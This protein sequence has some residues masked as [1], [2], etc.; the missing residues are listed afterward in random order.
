MN[1]TPRS[2]PTKSGELRASTGS[3]CS[4]RSPKMVDNNKETSIPIT[5]EFQNPPIQAATFIRI[6]GYLTVV[7]YLLT[8]FVCKKTRKLSSPLYVSFMSFHTR[9]S[10]LYLVILDL[11][12][13]C[14]A[15]TGT[16]KKLR[17][18]VPYFIK[19][20]SL[21]VPKYERTIMYFTNFNTLN[22]WVSLFVILTF[23]FLMEL[24]VTIVD[25]L[26]V[27]CRSKNSQ[28]YCV[29]MVHPSK[30]HDKTFTQEQVNKLLLSAEY[31]KLKNSRVGLGPEA[32]NWQLRRT[33]QNPEGPLK[34]QTAN[35]S[36]C[37]SDG[38]Y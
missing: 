16:I 12:K 24:F 33:L 37:D 30:F 22:N 15:V 26:I 31:N 9:V 20:F 2:S 8:V 11:Y 32:W 28:R 10:E 5:A 23:V 36:S 13:R 21:Y 6:F 14:P 34:S 19:M 3:P 17:F 18:E 25:N 7:F 35:T 27:S 29:N 1:L 38:S 4:T